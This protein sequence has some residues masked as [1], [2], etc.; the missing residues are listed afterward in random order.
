MPGSDSAPRVKTDGEAVARHLAAAT[1]PAVASGGL[2]IVDQPSGSPPVVWALSD[3]EVPV[4]RLL[5]TA[6]W[7]TSVPGDEPIIRNAIAGPAELP[8]PGLTAVATVPCSVLVLPSIAPSTTLFLVRSA[9]SAGFSL[10]DALSLRTT[11]NPPPPDDTEPPTLAADA[12]EDAA[13]EGA[14]VDDGSTFAVARRTVD[15]VMRRFDADGTA[16]YLPAMSTL[17]RPAGADSSTGPVPPLILAAMSGACADLTPPRR[18]GGGPSTLIR[19]GTGDVH[20]AE[21]FTGTEPRRRERAG[22]VVL[23]APIPLDD[24]PGTG[25]LIVCLAPGHVGD[26]EALGEIAHAVS[27][28]LRLARA[29]DERAAAQRGLRMALTRQELVLAAVG[30]ML[31]APSLREGLAAFGDAL[32]PALADVLLVYLAEPPALPGAVRLGPVTRVLTTIA[33]HETGAETATICQVMD[34]YALTVLARSSALGDPDTVE[35]VLPPPASDETALPA[36]FVALLPP[37]VRSAL[38]V[39]MIRDGARTGLLIAVTDRSGRRRAFGD[40]TS[41]RALGPVLAEAIQ[42]HVAVP[43]S[44]A[45]GHASSLVIAPDGREV[46]TSLAVSLAAATTPEGVYR[47]VAHHVVLHVADWCVIDEVTDHGVARLLAIHRD[48]ERTPPASIWHDISAAPPGSHGPAMV[49]HTDHADFVPSMHGW[50]SPYVREASPLATAIRDMRTVAHMSIPIHQPPGVLRAIV[51]GLNSDP[52]GDQTLDLLDLL[53]RMGAMASATLGRLAGESSSPDQP[54][55][56]QVI[57]GLFADAA[58]GVALVDTDGHYVYANSAFAWLS[59]SDP[60]AMPTDDLFRDLQ[61]LGLDGEPLTGQ[62]SPSAR[63]MASGQPTQTSVLVRRYGGHQTTARLTAIPLAQASQQP[64]GALL[65]MDRDSAS[66]H[67]RIALRAELDSALRELARLMAATE[68]WLQL[69]EQQQA[70]A[71]NTVR[72]MAAP[73]AVRGALDQGLAQIARLNQILA[74]AFPEPISPHQLL[75]L[76]RFVEGCIERFRHRH[77]N[78]H[79]SLTMHANHPIEIYADPG[80]IESIL[81]VMFDS[82]AGGSRD[83]EL[84]VSLDYGAEDD[85]I[86]V[87][88]TNPSW[89]VTDADLAGFLDEQSSRTSGAARSGSGMFG[90]LQTARSEARSLPGDLTLFRPAAGGRAVSL[91]L[92]RRPNHPA[93]LSASGQP[94]PDA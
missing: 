76:S 72:S 16:L 41:L 56:R 75:E 17:H 70:P 18:A 9:G 79:I 28:R 65:V 14:A 73:Q 46:L 29:A 15:L 60:S 4:T 32:V 62:R 68:G 12:E 86:T 58:F 45:S 33:D 88:V 6:S 43:R 90:P 27:Q 78:T 81:S 83:V 47:A 36:E 93:Q 63:A 2:V 55:P 89:S 7:A 11:L 64:A 61:V 22:A 49:L 71:A 74:V 10:D 53:E 3:G 94:F 26:L 51:T 87:T 25:V 57:A 92:P 37:S 39:A 38:G 8:H 67:E 24:R 20:L 1:I 84:A 50:Q 80:Q 5:V 82:V 35:F 44:P 69:L 40:L 77:G 13:D 59:G 85:T 52:S 23:E 30:R 34:R 31:A 91:R 21:P 66:H 54:S 48:P 42:S 19:D